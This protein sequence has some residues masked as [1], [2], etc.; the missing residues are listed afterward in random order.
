MPTNIGFDTYDRP[1]L[2]EGAD[3]GRIVEVG[4][5]LAV[6]L[7]PTDPTV[8][9][10]ARSVDG[11]NTWEP[12]LGETPSTDGATLMDWE[13]LSYGD[14]LYRAVAET[15]EGATSS[16]VI[17]VQARSGA[18]WLSGG[19][20]YGETCRLPLSPQRSISGGRATAARQ[21]AGR[22]RPVF[23]KGHALSDVHQIAGTV[24]DRTRGGEADSTTPD[25]LRALIQSP[26]PIHMLRTPDGERI[27]G[28]V[29]GY[30]VARNTTTQDDD[31]LRPWNAFW[32]YSFELTEGTGV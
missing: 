14:T 26:E 17:T 32:G 25:A 20:G 19:V 11:G 31:P 3:E 29:S 24:T 7:I 2:E 15:V 9:T 21:Y 28:G 1:Y 23:D 18:L 22:S 5:R 30:Q 16:T 12:V 13:S 8:F 10:L 6:E 4:D 27:Y